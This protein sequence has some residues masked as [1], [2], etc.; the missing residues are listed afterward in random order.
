LNSSN[1][2][3]IVVVVVKLSLLQNLE[4]SGIFF[5]MRF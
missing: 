4:I 1:S 5:F 3:L 2:I